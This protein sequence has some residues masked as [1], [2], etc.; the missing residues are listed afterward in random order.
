MED[1]GGF[2]RAAEKFFDLI[3]SSVGTL[4][5]PRAI[6]TEGK[7]KADA[8]AYQV[9]AMAKAQ[10]ES[11]LIASE[12]DQAL[13]ERAFARLRQQEMTKQVNVESIIEKT[14]IEIDGKKVADEVDK[15]WMF[16]FFESC[17]TISDETIQKYWAQVLA[18]KVT[19]NSRLPRRLIDCLRWMD[20]DL[21]D[22]FAEMAVRIELFGGFF[23]H[24]IEF[25]K[26]RLSSISNP[27]SPGALE[28]VGLIKEETNRTFDFECFALRVEC[29]ELSDRS[30]QFRRFY[31]FTQSGRILARV[32]VPKIRSYV[33]F[34]DSQE[35]GDQEFHIF[36]GNVYGELRSRAEAHL[37]SSA[38]KR[39]IAAGEITHFL[40]ENEACVRIK[41][42]IH[43]RRGA[44]TVHD[45]EDVMTLTNSGS[46]LKIKRLR[47]KPHW[48]ALSQS[49]REFLDEVA[50]YAECNKDLIQNL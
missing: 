12:A 5:K 10:G 39:A 44:H 17:S 33:Q 45:V 3:S 28:E 16:Y 8:D 9:V 41:K 25:K 19:G 37:M 6:R 20:V 2:G 23:A 36:H 43:S 15:D 7:A 32:V 1:L 31:D 46:G 38:K 48:K 22:R 42:A 29:T 30:I 40:M 49:E 35:K 24:R 26:R 13:A 11:K 34:I 21:A 4:Y 50:A 14:S 27:F 47:S 18:Q